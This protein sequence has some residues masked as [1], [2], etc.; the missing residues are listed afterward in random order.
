LENLEE[1]CADRLGE[2]RFKEHIANAATKGLNAAMALKRLRMTSPS[3]ARPLFEATVAPV[4]DYASNIWNHACG[5]AAIPALNRVQR[6]GAQAITGVFRTV[7]SVIREAEASI[8]PVQERHK[9]KMAAFWVHLRTLPPT[10]PLTRLH[11]GSYRRFVSPLQRIA[12]TFRRT[13]TAAMERIQP[14]TIAPWEAR[15]A[16]QIESDD[17]PIPEGIQIATSSSARNQVVGLGAP[18]VTPPPRCWRDQSRIQ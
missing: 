4:V 12:W 5:S 15:V 16:V 3:T 6:T 11:T 9:G 17:T 7:A 2:L 8:K 18:F 1:G 10:N 14:Y 13:S